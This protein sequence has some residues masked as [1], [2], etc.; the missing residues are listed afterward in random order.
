MV[1]REVKRTVRSKVKK[2]RI[3]LKHKT[4]ETREVYVLARNEVEEEKRRTK[5]DVLINLGEAVKRD[6]RGSKN[7]VF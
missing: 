1:D 4:P 6:I 5:R 2:M 3:W 7:K